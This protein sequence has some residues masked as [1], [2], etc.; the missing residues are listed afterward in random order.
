MQM[1]RDGLFGTAR[2]VS[3]VAALALTSHAAQAAEPSSDDASQKQEIG[4]DPATSASNPLTDAGSGGYFHYKVHCESCHGY[5]GSGTSKAGPLLH[6]DY[7]KDYNSRKAFH[8]NFHASDQPHRRVSR[9]TRKR[10]GPGFNELEMIAKFLRE[11][12]A[13]HEIVNDK[14]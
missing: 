2:V 1:L 7:S 5:L 12:E 3:I 8:S 14:G 11:I 4:P 6:T 9:G 13:W 10:P